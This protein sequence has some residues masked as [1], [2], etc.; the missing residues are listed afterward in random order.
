MR[1]LAERNPGDPRFAVELG[2]MLT[3][4]A[5][6]RA[7]GIR[8][9][10]AHPKDSNAQTAIRQALIWDAA[11]PTSAAEL[12]QYLHDHPQ[13]AELAGYL[14]ENEFK[15]AQMNSGIARTPAERLAFAALNAH[16]LEDA[17][18]RFTEILAQQPENPM[19][20][21]IFHRTDPEPHSTAQAASGVS[22][23]MA[24][25]RPTT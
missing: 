16:K 22:A 13:D 17:E 9:L 8:L 3:Y 12:R 18:K 4:D 19:L 5:K 11:N 1:A 15:L 7:E 25:T 6:T 20:D 21:P 14:K 2:I 24:V 10:Q 23:A